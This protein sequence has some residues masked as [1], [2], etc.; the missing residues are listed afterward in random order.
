MCSRRCKAFTK[1][2]RG[3]LNN[4]KA[5]DQQLGVIVQEPVSNTDCKI[6][7]LFWIVLNDADGKKKS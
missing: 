1:L 7:Q 3:L 2:A 5:A 4:T 6:S